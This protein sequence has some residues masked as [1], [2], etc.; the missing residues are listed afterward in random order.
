MKDIMMSQLIESDAFVGGH[1]SV[2]PLYHPLCMLIVPFEI[3]EIKGVGFH[4]LLV[5]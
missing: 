5:N 4:N 3:E 1:L 2:Y